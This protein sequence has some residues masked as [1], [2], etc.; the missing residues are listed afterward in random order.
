MSGPSGIERVTGPEALFAAIGD[1][2]IH[3]VVA[4]GIAA[5]MAALAVLADVLAKRATPPGGSRTFLQRLRYD[6][7][8]YGL[9]CG[10]FALFGLV[11]AYFLA[12]GLDAANEDGV[13]TLVSTFAT[14]LVSLL[15]AGVAFVAAKSKSQITSN[16]LVLGVLSFLI[17]CVLSYHT[18]TKQRFEYKAKRPDVAM[19]ARIDAG[20][21]QNIVL[22]LP[23][24]SGPVGE[25]A[26]AAPRDDQSPSPAF[27]PPPPSQ[28]A[29][30]GP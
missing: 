17:A 30:G 2:Y 29:A 6:A 5:S 12:L 3:F 27:S 9:Y 8:D 22:P 11:T 23:S 21:T 24:G 20:P 26:L 4:L 15:T 25:P 18:H 1:L 19:S 28:D 14:P 16:E 13:N 7:I 10:A